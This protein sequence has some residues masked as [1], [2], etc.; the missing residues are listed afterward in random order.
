MLKSSRWKAATIGGLAGGFLL[1]AGSFGAAGASCPAG[2]KSG[3][4]G[5][6]GV[7]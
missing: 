3:H 2:H 6:S 1:V 7:A 4:S 5:I